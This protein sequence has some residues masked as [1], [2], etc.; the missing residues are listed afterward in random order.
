MEGVAGFGIPAMLIAPFMVSVGYRP[1]TCVVLPLAADTTA[2]M[3]GALGTPVKLGM[4]MDFVSPEIKLSLIMNIL[5]ALLVPF[6]LAWLYGRTERKKI[7]WHTEWPMLLAAGFCFVVPFVLVGQISV[8]FPSVA[9]GLIGLVPFVWFSLPKMSRLSYQ[10]WLNTFF[11]YLLFVGLLIAVKFLLGDIGFSFGEGLKSVSLYQPGLVF[12]VGTL[13][14]LRLVSQKSL[15]QYTLKL[16]KITLSRLTVPVL[17]IL[18]LV[19]FAQLIRPEMAALAQ[20]IFSEASQITSLGFVPLAGIFGSFIT[21]SATMSVMLFNSSVMTLFPA[22]EPLSLRL[23]ML[24]TGAAIGNAISFQNI[25]MVQSVVSPPVSISSV[26]YSNIK[27]VLI[28]LFVL[29]IEGVLFS[30]LSM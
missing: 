10:V 21:G 16:A 25:V 7:E 2:V 22:G 4:D 19:I 26:L 14:Y 29:I 23:A 13:L 9:A 20:Q 24:L 17:T 3:F 27:F 12:I 18:F 5:P 28:Y 30:Y 15:F 6:V 11:P 8:E 1:L